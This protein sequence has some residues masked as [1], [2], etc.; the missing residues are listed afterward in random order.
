MKQF[1]QC[2]CIPFSL[3]YGTMDTQYESLLVRGGTFTRMLGVQIVSLSP[4]P[5]VKYGTK[6]CRRVKDFKLGAV[7]KVKKTLFGMVVKHN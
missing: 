7:K 4:P 5:L 3:N 1:S 2:T 6:A